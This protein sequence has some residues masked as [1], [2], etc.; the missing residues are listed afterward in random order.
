VS[1]GYDQD[2]LVR[3]GFDAP[4]VRKPYA[5]RDMDATPEASGGCPALA[6]GRKFSEWTLGTPF[7]LS[8]TAR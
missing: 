6:K 8:K 3:T 2:E 7:S 1:L 5:T 4:F